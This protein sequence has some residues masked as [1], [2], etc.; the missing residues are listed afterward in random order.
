MVARGLTGNISR[1]ATAALGNI[2]IESM[3][4]EAHYPAFRATR[5]AR[6]SGAA[7]AAARAGGVRGL[8]QMRPSGS[9][10][11]GFL[12]VR[13]ERYHAEKLVAL[14]CKRRGVCP[15]CGARRM[16]ETAALL[17]DEV[18]PRRP[19]PQWVLSFPFALRFLLARDPQVLTQVLEIVYRTIS[20]HILKNARLTRASGCN[21]LTFRTRRK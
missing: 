20:G 12:R 14:S 7:T 16:A 8:P 18:L 19:L 10:E 11:E 9:L 21:P 4:H 2:S 6:G 17:V 13:C 15:S 1:E 5:D 3:R